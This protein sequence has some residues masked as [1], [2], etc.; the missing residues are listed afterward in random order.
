MMSGH[1][2]DMLVSRDTDSGLNQ[3]GVR[4]GLNPY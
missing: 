2:A 3:S 4:D 1:D